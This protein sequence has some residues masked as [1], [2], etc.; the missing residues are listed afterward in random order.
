MRLNFYTTSDPANLI[1]K[2]LSNQL[3]MEITLNKDVDVSSPVLILESPKQ[4]GFYGYNY[5]DI[6]LLNR[7]YFID[8]IDNVGGNFWRCALRCD[9]LDTYI[10]DIKESRALFHRQIKTGDCISDALDACIYKTITTFASNKSLSGDPV[11]VLTTV[12]SN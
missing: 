2:K 7:R 5:A 12:G 8:T 4:D 1:G 10:I 11:M 9:V 6:P 3:A